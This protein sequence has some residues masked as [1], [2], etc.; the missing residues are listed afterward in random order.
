ML[1]V[2]CGYVCRSYY[3]C[4]SAS[5]NVKKRVERSYTDPS[6][7]VTTYEGQHTH[8]SPVMHR[9]GLAGAPIPPGAVSAAGFATNNFGNSVFPGNYLSQYHQHHHHHHQQQLLVNTLSSLGFPNY[10][11]SSSKN[12]AFTH[13]RQQRLCNNP[14]ATAFLKDHGLL[15]DV[16]PSHMLKEE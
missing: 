16:V 15:Q 14:G 12:A 8:P 2:M 11:D 1:C 5:C 6:I 10:N 9:S 7:V 3:R 13:E 4:T